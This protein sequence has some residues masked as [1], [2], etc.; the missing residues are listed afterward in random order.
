[1]SGRVENLLFR[2]AAKRR[3]PSD[4]PPLLVELLDEVPDA[5]E[6]TY[7][8]YP[9]RYR[10]SGE[11]VGTYSIG[12]ELDQ[13]EV[14]RLRSVVESA[15]RELDPASVSPLTF[16]RLIEVLSQ[17][18][19]VK[20]AGGWSRARVNPLSEL[21]A[22]EAVGMSRILA[23][24]RDCHVTEF[25][26]DS[27]S[28]PVYVDHDLIGRCE[29]RIILTGR[30]REAVET[31]LDTF[32]GYSLDYRT[33]SM[34]NDME[35][36]GAR[37][38]VSLD[39]G[40]VSVNRFSLDVRRLNI[41]SLGLEELVERGVLTWAAG[42]LLVGW[43]ESGGNVTIVGETG[44]GKTTL[45]NALDEQVEPKLRRV[46]VEDAVETRDLL[47]KGF[48][49]MKVKVD[50]FERGE[51]TGRKKEAEIVK[52]L[53]RSPDILVLSEIQSEEHSRAFF[54]ALSAG[55]KGLQ[56]FHA[57][58]LEQALRR[59]NVV[60]HIPKESLLDLGVLV[61]MTRPQRL[62]PERFVQRVCQVVEQDGEP[63][64]MDL[65]VRD[66]SFRLIPGKD[67]ARLSPPRGVTP[68][69]MASKMEEVR[70]R[71]ISDPNHAS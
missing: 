4:P 37:L 30:E 23:L 43:L 58:T 63:V 24:A 39:L 48:H 67:V 11:G 54:H 68:T 16:G 62:R 61:Q 14:S 28:S 70:A 9:F 47:G 6:G 50:P 65:S 25:F 27:D 3:A 51:Q 41:S 60:H 19:A 52:A 40:P 13:A 69:V 2:F 22:Y 34:K 35:V 20:L 38:R 5:L 21:V 36:S 71:I 59:W 17:Q 26:A 33:P 49:Q 45:L 66:D 42:A 18:A 56:T 32:R 12:C 31:H 64:L 44:T 29:T 8:S 10:A 53:H 46:Y 15:S 57:S 1:M 55:A 7:S